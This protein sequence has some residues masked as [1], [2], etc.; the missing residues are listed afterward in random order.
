[1]PSSSLLTTLLKEYQH[2]AAK[3]P[4][5]KSSV[6]SKLMD[7][8]PSE[9]GRRD[10]FWN[11]SD[12]QKAEMEEVKRAYQNGELR[13]LTFTAIFREC[14]PLLDLRCCLGTFRTHMEK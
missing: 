12:D 5:G 10:P 1:M 7:L 11:L 14:K 9:Q 3:E 6:V 4:K 8:P 13:H 2:M